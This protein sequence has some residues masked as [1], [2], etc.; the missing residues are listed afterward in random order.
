MAEWTKY[1]KGE[2]P[3]KGTRPV[4]IPADAY[5]AYKDKGYTKIVGTEARGFLF[6]APLALALEI[7]FIP[8]RKP[9]KQAE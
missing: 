7:G 2:L 6:G 4:D 9:S 1:C 5:K 3:E 8:V